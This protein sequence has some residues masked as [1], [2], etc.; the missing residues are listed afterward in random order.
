MLLT[1]CIKY[2]KPTRGTLQTPEYMAAVEARNAAFQEL[3]NLSIH[4]GLDDIEKPTFSRSTS[5]TF[6][7]WVK[8][9]KK[10][11]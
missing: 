4:R 7:R 6:S 1:C 5:S 11:N 8:K 2:R 10:K 3:D 9:K